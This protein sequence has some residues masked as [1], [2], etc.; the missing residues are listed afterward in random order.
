MLSYVSEML[1]KIKS[2]F[3]RWTLHFC[4]C[5]EYSETT[6]AYFAQH[7]RFASVRLS[8]T[9]GR[10]ADIREEVRTAGG[11]W[12]RNSAP[13]IPPIWPLL[14]LIILCQLPRGNV[15]GWGAATSRKAVDS[16]PKQI[17]RFFN[18][19]NSSSRTMSL[20]ST[21]SLTEM[22]TRNLPGGKGWRGGS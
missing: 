18:W 10:E 6:K 15:V 7:M 17:I 11:Y 5:W 14:Y 21:Q 9:K 1:M 16:S 19:H 2:S 8:F 22:S 12:Q 3:M 4:S 20:G 13:D